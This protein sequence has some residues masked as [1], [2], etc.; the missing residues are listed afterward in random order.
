M[1]RSRSM[2]YGFPLAFHRFL[3]DVARDRERVGVSEVVL[4]L[5]FK[6][7]FLGSCNDLQIVVVE[8]QLVLFVV[9]DG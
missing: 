1:A 4:L 5:E 8:D 9:V 3:A 6:T 7:E 2:G